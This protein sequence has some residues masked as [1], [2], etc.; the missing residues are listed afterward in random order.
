M[1]ALALID[2]MM[3]FPVIGKYIDY[4][5]DFIVVT[6]E[7]LMLYDQGGIFHREEITI[8]VLNIKTISIRKDK[9]LYSIFDN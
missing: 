5:M 4:K 8:G 6:P 9:L 1:I 7:S 2:V 3:F